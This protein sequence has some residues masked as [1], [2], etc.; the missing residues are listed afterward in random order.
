MYFLLIGI[1]VVILMHS[2]LIVLLI[3]KNDELS[4]KVTYLYRKTYPYTRTKNQKVSE[5]QQK[6]ELYKS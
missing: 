3:K 5:P 2:F 6:R 1:G 4:R